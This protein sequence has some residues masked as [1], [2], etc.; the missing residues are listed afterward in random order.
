[1]VAVADGRRQETSF[2]R[3]SDDDYR[4]CEIKGA[5]NRYAGPVTFQLQTDGSNYNATTRN[6]QEFFGFRAYYYTGSD[7]T[8]LQAMST[9][10]T[11]RMDAVLFESINRT[12]SDVAGLTHDFSFLCP[13]RNYTV[14]ECVKEPPC[15]PPCPSDLSLTCCGGF[16]VPFDDYGDPFP[17][18]REV[19]MVRPELR[20][21]LNPTIAPDWTGSMSRIMQLT[22]L[23]GRFT[24]HY[25]YS[26]SFANAKL[27]IDLES[28]LLMFHK[29]DIKNSLWRQNMTDALCSVHKLCTTSPDAPSTDSV[30]QTYAAFIDAIAATN[31]TVRKCKF[32]VTSTRAGFMTASMRFDYKEHKKWSYDPNLPPIYEDGWLLQPLP[33]QPRRC[34]ADGSSLTMVAA[35]SFSTFTVHTRDQY[36]N[37]R[38]LGG[39]VVNAL[40]I[41]NNYSDPQQLSADVVNNGNGTYFVEYLLTKTGNYFLAINIIP[42]G[43]IA[44]SKVNDVLSSPLSVLGSPFSI[45]VVSGPINADSI[46]ILGNMQSGIASF[47]LMHVVRIYDIYGNLASP[48][49]A[50][51]LSVTVPHA[52]NAIPYQFPRTPSRFAAADIV[53]LDAPG[54]FMLTWMP[55]MTGWH[56]MS[57]LLNRSSINVHINNSPLSVYVLPAPIDASSSEASGPLF[58]MSVLGV[59]ERLSGTITLRDA[60][61]NVRKEA[62]FINSNR[63]AMSFRGIEISDCPYIQNTTLL[64][65]LKACPTLFDGNMT[66]SRRCS[67]SSYL[68]GNTKPSVINSFTLNGTTEHTVDNHDKL[69]AW[70]SNTIRGNSCDQIARIAIDTASKRPR[71]VPL[72]RW[73]I[74]PPKSG[75]AKL[76]NT[77]RKMLISAEENDLKER[78]F[79]ITVACTAAGLY[80][81]LVSVSNQMLQGLPHL[82][83]VQAGSPEASTAR[84]FGSLINTDYLDRPMHSGFLSAG[85]LYEV[86]VALRDRFGNFVWTGR[87]DLSVTLGELRGYRCASSSSCFP[88]PRF[89]SLQVSTSYALHRLIDSDD[90]SYV[91]QAIMPIPG[92]FDVNVFVLNGE[93]TTIVGQSPYIV[94]VASGSYVLENT[95][96]EGQGVISCG[97]GVICSFSVI[98]RDRF[99]NLIVLPS[100]AA[101]LSHTC[102]LQSCNITNGALNAYMELYKQ[103]ELGAALLMLSSADFKVNSE[104]GKVSVSYNI[105][106]AGQYSWSVL[107]GGRPAPGSPFRFSIF[108]GITSANTTIASGYGLL[109]AHPAF[110][111]T[112]VIRTRDSFSNFKTAGG[113]IMEVCTLQWLPE[114]V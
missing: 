26:N 21:R 54:D 24:E 105:Q 98:N 94:N 78:V 39:E 76:V 106:E 16:C 61:G 23:P 20:Y 5:M 66:L 80:R 37:P 53:A 111:S 36:S 8:N 86:N 85:E 42:L 100:T 45:A 56:T 73:D 89:A 113:D 50:A 40:L 14:F 59:S 109:C 41:S 91:V 101:S 6:N 67:S 62:E 52:V 82:L 17:T 18:T 60:V 48:N 47:Y 96:V 31:I 15:N 71:K 69:L 33:V 102:T 38:I 79:S 65:I 104:A 95:Y 27:E 110:P 2:C 114:Q 13:V 28:K 4:N 19:V 107:V 83:L 72:Q 63:F 44:P 11:G 57:I 46:T 74:V 70:L 10:V 99:K 55:V 108:G 29:N 43:Q 22:A 35:G 84:V 25:N 75:I 112:F 88:H 1:M 64:D 68:A 81:V 51:R 30:L 58:D 12:L 3:F 34:V 90:G 32:S 49:V 9:L 87:R 92:Q 93:S 103:D 7:A 77:S 97:A